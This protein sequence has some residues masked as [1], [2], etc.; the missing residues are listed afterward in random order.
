[1]SRTRLRFRVM[2]SYSAAFAST[3]SICDSITTET[4][5]TSDGSIGCSPRAGIVIKPVT[6][7]SV[8]ANY[9]VAYLPSS[10]DQFSSL[11]DITQQVKPE[12][13]SNYEV[14]A[15]WELEEISR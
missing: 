12:K 6:P 1:M 8:Y 4:M 14:G 13:F 9:G 7:L 11:T 2:W 15:K 3:T 10:G 5:K